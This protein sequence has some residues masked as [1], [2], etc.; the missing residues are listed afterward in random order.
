MMR[1]LS[2]L[3]GGV[4]LSLAPLYGAEIR[5][6]DKG[7]T[8]L[9]EWSGRGHRERFPVAAGDAAESDRAAADR[10]RAP[11]GHR[12]EEHPRGRLLPAGDGRAHLRRATAGCGLPSD[13]RMSTLLT[14][15]GLPIEGGVQGAVTNRFGYGFRTPVDQFV[16]RTLAQAQQLSDGARE[17][18]F[19]VPNRCCRTTCRR[20]STA[21]GW[22]SASPRARAATTASTARRS[23]C[24]RSS[25][26]ARPN[27][28]S[29]RRPFRPSGIHVSGNPVDGAEIQPRMPWV[30]LDNYNSNGYRGVVA[31]EDKPHFGLSEPQPDPGRRDPA[32]LRRQPARALAT[33]SNRSSPPTPS[34]CAPTSPGTIARGELIGRSHRPGR[35]GHRPRHVPVRRARRASGPPPKAGDHRLEAAGLRPLHG[36]G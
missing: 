30:M 18:D 9:G 31:D 22:I 25:R 11:G 2:V 23:P 28:T 24:G 27:R 12:A 36:A 3:A 4:L 20:A 26:A 33:R 16:T 19:N 14:P 13:E 6:G 10:R 29:T 35:Q 7:Y 17:V 34:S 1:T 32:A 21:C 8:E 5:F 15:T